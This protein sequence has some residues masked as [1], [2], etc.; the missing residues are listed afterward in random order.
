VHACYRALASV[1]LDLGLDAERGL[2]GRLLWAGALDA[3]RSR[4]VRAANT[5]GAASLAAAEPQEGKAAMRAGVVDFLVTTLDEALR[6]LKNEIR[7]GTRVAVCVALPEDAVRAEMLERGLLPD[8]LP[9]AG[10]DDALEAQ[11][12]RRLAGAP[13]ESGRVFAAVEIPQAQMARAAEFEALL[14]EAMDAADAAGARWLRL[15]PRY[16]PASMR[17]V[18]SVECSAE[19]CAR[20]M[21]RAGALLGE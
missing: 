16:L 11:G 4:L 12:A 8:L 10:A 6:I 5:A 1:G 9:A 21:E 2:G 18:R 19:S 17:R 14:A 20:L 3:Q 15:S 7:K 13:S